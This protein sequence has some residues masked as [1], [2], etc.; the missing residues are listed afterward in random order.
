MSQG[1]E[2]FEQELQALKDSYADQ[3]PQKLAEIDALWGSLVD[4]GW[5][6]EIF[7]TLHRMV[8]SMAG[9]AQ[10]FGFTTMGKSARELEL[11]L[12][13]VSNSGEPLSEAHYAELPVL[14]EAVRA[15]AQ[16]PDG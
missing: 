10:V 1:M 8:H 5:D 15:S 14:V 6:E 16:F 4:N 7:K 13:A 11:L 9:S 2:G 12:K 3:V